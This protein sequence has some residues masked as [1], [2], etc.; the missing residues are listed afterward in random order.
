MQFA[1]KLSRPVVVMR[2]GAGAQTN[3]VRL[4]ANGNHCDSA[5]FWEMEGV[6]FYDDEW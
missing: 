5:L 2:W 1:L 4:P 3:V 6:T